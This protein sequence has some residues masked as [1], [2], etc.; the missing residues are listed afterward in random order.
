MFNANL[1]NLV[2]REDQTM[3][4]GYYV[5][6]RDEGKAIKLYWDKQDG[7]WT[8]WFSRHCLFPTIKAANKQARELASYPIL[9]PDGAVIGTREF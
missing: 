9:C 5:Y 6:R 8:N 2:E 7:K 4:Y 1:I 3:Q